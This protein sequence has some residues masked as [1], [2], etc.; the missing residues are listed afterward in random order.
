METAGESGKRSG[1]RRATL[2]GAGVVADP[3]RTA[4]DDAKAGDTGAFEALVLRYQARIVNYASAMVRDAG[5]AEDV[6][7]ETFV[8]AWRG[9][10][11]FRGESSFKTW[12]Y[13]I[14]TNVARIHLARRGHQAQIADRSLDNESEPLQAGDVPSPAPDAETSPRHTR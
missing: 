12:L 8:R 2:D 1:R 7:Q 4:V 10:G 9:L 14:A 13:R 3:D 6:A 5:G 11:R